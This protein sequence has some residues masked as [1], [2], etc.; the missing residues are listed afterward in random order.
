[1]AGDPGVHAPLQ[2]V[3]ALAPALGS[4]GSLDE[5]ARATLT[6]LLELPTVVRVAIALSHGGG[7]QLQF[8]SSDADRMGAALQWCLIDSFDRVPLNDAARTRQDVYLETM[9]EVERRYPLI[10][11]RQRSLG[12][13]GLAA[14]ALSAGE[15]SLGALLIAFGS[16][17]TFA[18]E[19][20]LL[21]AALAA[22]VSQALQRERMLGARLSTAEALHR[23]LMPTEV[24]QPHGL[25]LCARYQAGGHDA[26]L[27]GDWYDVFDTAGG[28]TA[29]VVGDVM[30]KGV[31]A[32]VLMGEI[33]TAL[34]AYALTDPHPS[35]VLPLLDRFVSTRGDPDQLVTV[36][37]GLVSPDRTRLTWSI[38]GH[39]PPILVRPDSAPVVLDQ[40]RGAALG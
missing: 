26:G 36:V 9:E 2:V 30:G 39:P 23:S 15:E 27:G 7:R 31:E 10:A 29:F 12:T 5:I 25:A 19:E 38:A 18:P 20:R 22:Q 28:S 8:V 34:R 37:Y 32:A 16:E 21:L 3:R 17:Q 40:P 1:M 24:P 4:A 14:L 6:G 35:A 33:R 13:R 11:E